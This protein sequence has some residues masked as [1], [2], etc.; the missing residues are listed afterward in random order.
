MKKL[1]CWFVGCSLVLSAAAADANVTLHLTFDGTAEAAF[2][3]G[4]AAPRRAEGLEFGPG[5]F[6]QAVRLTSAAKSVLA[7]AAKGNIDWKRGSMSFWMKREEGSNGRLKSLIEMERGDRPGLGRFAFAFNKFN[8]MW[9]T[10]DALGGRATDPA[11][12]PLAQ[13]TGVW[14]QWVVTWGVRSGGLRIYCGGDGTREFQPY[15]SDEEGNRIMP[16]RVAGAAKFAD[17]APEPELFFL[18]SSQDAKTK[19]LEG[20]LDEVKVYDRQLSTAEVKALFEKSRRAVIASAPHFGLADGEATLRVEVEPRTETLDGA[21]VALVDAQGWERASAAV[22]AATRTAT[23]AAVRVPM[24]RYEYRLLKSDE[25]LAR[26]DYTALRSGNPYE[27]PPTATPG[28]PRSLK[29]V[30]VVK[31]DLATLTTNEFR[32]VGKC[33]MGTLDGAT[34]LEGGR[35]Q[36]DRFALRLRLPTSCPLYLIDVVYPDDKFRTMDLL[37]QP[38]RGDGT[39]ATGVSGQGGDYSFAQGISTGR[40]YPNSGKMRH[41]RCLYWSGTSDDLAF[42]AMSWMPGAP[43]AV[44][45]LRIYEVADAALPVADVRTSGVGDAMGRQFGQFWEDPNATGALRYNMA[46]P[47]AFSE[48]IDRYASIM[49]YCGQNTLSYPGGWYKGLIT[50]AN[51]PRAGTHVDHYLEG[52]YAKFAKEGLYV[53]PSIEFIFVT[54]PPDI[55]A[56]PEMITNGTLHATHYPI[57]S[58]GLPAQKFNHSL[59][60]V[61]NFFHPET[62]REIEEMFRALVKE[63]AAYP[64]FKGISLQ[65]YRDSALWWGDATSGYNDYCIEAFERDTGVK[66]VADR[67]D[68]LR[69]KAYY[70]WLKANAW[71][72]WIAWRC[73]KFTAFYARMAKILSDARPDLRLWFIA[74]PRFDAVSELEQNPDY[75]SE[76][77]ASRSLKEAGFDGEMVAKAI[78]NAITGVTVHPQRHRKRWYWAKTQEKFDRYVGLPAGEGYYR[79]MQKGAF[80]AVTCRDEFMETDV[81]RKSRGTPQALSGGWL[82]E[83]GWRCSTINAAGVH[84][85]R[86]FAVPLRFGDVLGFT[87]GSFLVC[88]YGYEPL[89]AR[90]A[91]AFRALPPEKMADWPCETDAPA[92]VRVRHLEKDGRHWFYAVNTEATPAKVS[93][94]TPVAVRDTVSGRVYAPGAVSLDLA[95]YELRSFIKEK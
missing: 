11:F 91:Q 54:N 87:R 75:F 4:D 60:P 84:G 15:V 44:S 93:F 16:N 5:R 1:V 88:D 81:G 43:A 77:F 6:G 92:V 28:E 56:T 18:G 46:T 86:Y 64:S 23:L 42:I 73:E 24:G 78:P 35:G 82:D 49:R 12:G 29:L 10:R 38:A 9:A 36:Y 94:E 58:T 33:T 72:R 62:Q 41:H 79:E 63:G 37:V 31:P 48:Q 53:M 71:D 65:L 45:E 32:A 19:P 66:V 90:F 40:E 17:D 7:Y 57:Q 70:E 26:D 67:A 61:S 27:L 59:P 39:R 51:D 30:K 20:W 69:G 55:E 50:V 25:I 34:Y 2:A 85:M 76:D 74:A 80:P 95:P 3:K 89:E 14:E 13:G 83:I 21:R 68:P 22:D 8:R 52:Y 47:F